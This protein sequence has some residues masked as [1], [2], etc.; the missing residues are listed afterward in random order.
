ML[1][2]IFNRRLAYL[3]SDDNISKELMQDINIYN[4]PAS[5]N[6]NKAMAYKRIK[7]QLIQSIEK[8]FIFKVYAILFENGPE[9]EKN[10][11]S[12][13]SS[14]VIDEDLVR[15]LNLKNPFVA[16]K[17]TSKDNGKK[18]ITH[19]M[20]LGGINLNN[21]VGSDLSAYYFIDPLTKHIRVEVDVKDFYLKE[22]FI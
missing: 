9:A 13:A 5:K 6:V 21:F 16:Y 12:V 1:D 7:L 2:Y 22:K 19:L 18:I 10:R 17:P 4:S 14:L 11:K 20:Y 3:L 15:A 8:S